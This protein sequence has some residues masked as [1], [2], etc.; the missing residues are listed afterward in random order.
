MTIADIDEFIVN[1]S[2]QN[3]IYLSYKKIGKLFVWHYLCRY[4]K[5][6]IIKKLFFQV[7]FLLGISKSIINIVYNIA[8]TV[9]DDIDLTTKDECFRYISR[10]FLMIRKEPCSVYQKVKYQAESDIKELEMRITDYEEKINGLSK[11]TSKLID[12]I[13]YEK[14]LLQHFINRNKDA[15][16]EIYD[17]LEIEINFWC[18]NK[19]V[20]VF[21]TELFDIPYNYAWWPSKYTLL[22]EYRFYNK[23]QELTLKKFK[24]IIAE[25]KINDNS[26]YVNAKNYIVQYKIYEQCKSLLNSNHI[27]NR[28][29]SILEKILLFYSSDAYVFCVLAYP[30]IEGLFY[31]YCKYLNFT[32]ND[33]LTSAISEKSKKLYDQKIINQYQYNYYAHMFPVIRNRLAHGIEYE[34]DFNNIAYMLLLDLYDVIN[35]SLKN[36]F[37]FNYI[38]KT[39]KNVENKKNFE[40]ISNFCLIIDKKID[41][42]YDLDSR[43]NKLNNEIKWD[44]Y[45][46]ELSDNCLKTEVAVMAKI[47]AINLKNKSIMTDKC[48]EILRK[49]GKNETKYFDIKY[50]LMNFIDT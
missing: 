27:L 48:I 36:E 24:E 14:Y 32:E 31:E 21:G 45:L 8:K 39:V 20:N 9:D 40:C 34:M 44:T 15:L 7:V 28:R 11:N 35:I 30:Q 46:N 6:C 18:I 33:L 37:D 41:P 49:V 5:G 25:Y 43:V 13:N 47:I 2:K 4:Y 19:C 10:D 38:N 29:K 42:F 3:I 22:E 16:L 23:F 26:I 17:F 12:E 50:H 1:L